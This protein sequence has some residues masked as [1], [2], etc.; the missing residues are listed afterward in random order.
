M[1]KKAM[2]WK[3]KGMNRDLSVSAFSPEFAFENMNLRL[4]T[5][6]GNTQM[7]WVS[8]R[9]TRKITYEAGSDELV[10][11]P[12]GTAVIDHQLVLF[13]TEYSGENF[14]SNNDD[15]IYLLKY[16]DKE[17]SEMS[18]RQLCQKPMNF[19]AQYPLETL[20][21]YESET[22]QKVYWT[23]GRNQ[24]RLINIALPNIG[25]LLADKPSTYFDFVPALKLQEEVTVEKNIGVLGTFAAGVI[26]YS[27]TYFNK[28][29]QET[30]IFY[31]TPLLYISYSDRGGSPDAKINNAFTIKI[32]KVDK[33]FDYIRIYSIQRTSINATPLCKRVHD[34]SL[35]GITGNSV[36]YI[37]TGENGDS[38][39]PTELLYKGGN[40]IS[41]K[42]MAHKD[43][44]LF[45]GNLHILQPYII[46]YKS[47]IQE[48]VSITSG[49]RTL[50]CS[51]DVFQLSAKASRPGAYYNGS[52]TPCGG[53][54]T[55]NYYRLGVQF[56][57]ESGKWSD[58]I[59]IMKADTIDH[60]QDQIPLANGTIIQLPNFKGELSNTGG[61]L[62][63][64]LRKAG[65]LKIRPVVVFP[66]G[67]DRDVVCQAVATPALQFGEESGNS[68]M[69]YSSWFFRPYRYISEV[70]DKKP[71]SNDTAISPC[72]WR[73]GTLEYYVGGNMRYIRQQ[74]VEG[75]YGSN[76]AF[77]ID[78][79]YHTFH[80]PD[81]E[82][83][84]QLHS[85]DYNTMGVN[86]VGT[87]TFTHT[88]ADIDI[89]TETPSISDNGGFDHQAI[90]GQGPEGIVTGLFYEDSFVDDDENAEL[91]A[92][93]QQKSPAR[94]F[95]YPWQGTGSLNN[96]CARPAGKGIQSAKLK[97]KVISNYRDTETEL[98]NYQSSS[99]TKYSNPGMQ[100]FSGEDVEI[101]K[102][103]SNHIYMGNI[104]TALMPNSSSPIYT[105]YSG[106][107]VG[108]E[109]DVGTPSEGLEEYTYTV[110]T[111][112]TVSTSFNSSDWCK[113]DNTILYKYIKNEG[114]KKGYD[115]DGIGYIGDAYKDL[116]R[117]KLPVR[118]R[119]K[120]T[121]HF[122]GRIFTSS[123]YRSKVFS[124][125]AVTALFN[126]LFIVE[127]CH[128]TDKTVRYG[129]YSEDALCANSWVPCGEPVV[130]PEE[131]NASSKVTFYYDYGDSYFQKWDCLKTYAFTPE[132][133]NQVIEIGS[134]RLTTY[135]NIDGRY[136]RNRAQF[137]NLNMSPTN[138]NLMNMVYSQTDNFFSYKILPEST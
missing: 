15:H 57:H 134:F 129:G 7:S 64:S 62:F 9:G 122:I 47:A 21:S 102:L 96:D 55:G 32:N 74:E 5:N 89:Q 88:Y 135:I 39:D 11:L 110:E 8:E 13:T 3:T 111:H 18:C 53:F 77:T 38:V 98:W 81:V 31:T 16:T 112:S 60:L 116:S 46:D 50:T 44:T 23:D 92:F 91:R 126:K 56:Q 100:L 124:G 137:S 130:I 80:S 20:V 121:P 113:I 71:E 14:N 2:M 37:D 58:P 61:Q 87:V 117:K 118:M 69:H 93:D 45:F 72:S 19:S 34:I 105:A 40:S 24:P 75:T 22:I 131:S 83:D 108:T 99:S 35:T 120:S 119:Y 63:D 67:I 86:T 136:D 107:T 95:I 12:I 70:N 85:L 49:T 6:E 128:S 115:K 42:T 28:N 1:A 52:S 76:S 138:F 51:N 43:S 59:H 4:S 103:P 33:D 25:E 90:A 17:A 106:V 109:T 65:Y 10:G 30:G 125:K 114:W 78:M 29:G 27:F 26:Q 79:Y 68:T 66:T 84:T 94:F 36:S 133:I 54:K 127:V 48:R 82:F 97:K 104:D 73:G 41:A 101:R 132:D 123:E